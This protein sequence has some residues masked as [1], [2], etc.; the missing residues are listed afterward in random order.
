MYIYHVIPPPL[1][2]IQGG[3]L[4]EV[5]ALPN[6]L[7]RNN[8]GA[9]IKG[10][11]LTFSSLLLCSYFICC[12]IITIHYIL[13]RFKAPTQV[14]LICNETYTPYMEI[15]PQHRSRIGEA[16]PGYF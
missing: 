12:D 1:F 6:Y 4:F 8:S 11:L 14:S 9:S 7:P 2:P 3:K 10:G 15:L 13:Y 16:T 5:L